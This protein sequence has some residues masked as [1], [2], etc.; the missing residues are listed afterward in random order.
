M[1]GKYVQKEGGVSAFFL[2]FFQKTLDENDYK[3][4]NKSIGKQREH[5]SNRQVQ[6][7][8]SVNTITYFRR[9]AAYFSLPEIVLTADNITV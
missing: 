9:D 6:Q 4:Y 3:W 5:K 8:I 2:I 1:V 7:A